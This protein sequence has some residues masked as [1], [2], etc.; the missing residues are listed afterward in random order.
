MPIRRWGKQGVRPTVDSQI[1]PEIDDEDSLVVGVLRDVS[2]KERTVSKDA[3][4]D[5][6]E[7]AGGEGAALRSQTDQIA[8]QP[9]N[10]FVAGPLCPIEL[11]G[12]EGRP[13]R[14]LRHE[15]GKFRVGQARKLAEKIE[16]ALTNLPRERSLAIGEIVKRR[17]CAELLSLEQKGCLGAEQEQR[18]Q[19]AKAGRRTELVQPPAGSR[20]GDLI[21]VLQ[22][23]NEPGRAALSNCRGAARRIL[24]VVALALEEISVFR[25]RDEFL[26]RA[27]MIVK[28]SFPPARCRDHGRVMEIVIPDGV[29]AIAAERRGIH[30]A[31]FLRLV[32]GNE[33]DR[34]AGRTFSGLPADIGHDVI[35]AFV[36]KGLS[37]VEF[38]PSKW[39]SSIQ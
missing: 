33:I 34:A 39:Y 26:R 23:V 1:L 14:R 38:N 17:G 12:I 25:R 37:G 22:E 10:L 24:P 5:M 3:A 16:A 15:A 30:Q 7:R 28:I 9:D 36:M 32:L 29:Q 8:V 21:V 27:V 4:V 11:A 6:P 13:R 31:T 19:C 35:A 20:V 18:R 2:E